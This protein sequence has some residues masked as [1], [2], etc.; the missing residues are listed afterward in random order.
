MENLEDICETTS[1]QEGL[2]F[3]C[4]A[5]RDPRLYVEQFWFSFEGPLDPS[6]LC[7]A[8]QF[9]VD[10]HAILRTSFP[11]QAAERPV[12]VVY[13]TLELPWTELD[14][15]H[16]SSDFEAR[17]DELL[18]TDQALGF[19]LEHLPLLR[20]TLIRQAENRHR[21]IW[22][23]HHI[24]LDG[25]SL[26][27]LFRELD[28]AY[29]A[30]RRGTPPAL[31]QK[32]P[33]RDLARW[34]LARDLSADEQFWRD[35]L[36][37][38]THPTLWTSAVAGGTGGAQRRVVSR[39]LSE[40][41]TAALSRLA[42]EQRLTLG[43]VCQSLWAALAGRHLATTRVVLG[44]AV[45]GR[46]AQLE[47]VEGMVGLFA[48]AVPAVF[49]LDQRPALAWI[50]HQQQRQAI[51]EP[52]TYAPPAKV[53]QWSPFPSGALFDSLFGFENY[54]G[55]DQ[56]L[57]F[58]EGRIS[59]GLGGLF[60]RTNYPVEVIVAPGERLLFRVSF[61]PARLDA[62]TISDLP[63]RF[64]EL[65]RR[66]LSDSQ[67]PLLEL[68]V[69][70]GELERLRNWTR[71]APRPAAL[72]PTP[73][74]GRFEIVEPTTGTPVPVGTAG[75]LMLVSETV[76]PRP[77]GHRAR[78]RVDDT[79][80]HPTIELVADSGSSSRPPLQQEPTR[81]TLA[82]T[83]REQALAVMWGEILGIGTP[84]SVHDSFLSLGGDSILAIRLVA[85]ARREGFVFNA[86]DLF[87]RGTI[88]ELATIEAVTADAP[89]RREEA[90]SAP[91][92]PIQHWFLTGQSAAA[93]HHFN[94][95]VSVE[96]DPS[97]LPHLR[98]AAL[99]VIAHHHLDRTSWLQDDRGR[100]HTTLRPGLAST[101][102]LPFE[103]H[104][105]DGPE[106]QCRG[107]IT[108]TVCTW[109]AALDITK[110]PLFRLGVFS[111]HGRAVVVWVMHHL[112]VDALSWRILI[113]DLATACRQLEQGSPVDLPPVP[114]TFAAWAR[115]RAEQATSERVRSQ[116][117]FWTQ[118]L[119][120]NPKVLELDGPEP[121]APN[122]VCDE[123]EFS[124]RLG[125]APTE[126]LLRGAHAAYGT[127]IND[128]LLTALAH[129]LL[130]AR[131]GIAPATAFRFD[132]EGHGREDRDGFDTSRAVGWF[133]S[134]FP[135][136]L[137]I[138]TTNDLGADLR[139]IKRQLRRIPSHGVDFGLLAELQDP[140]VLAPAPES[141]ILFNYLGQ[142]DGAFS[143]PPVLGLADVPAGPNH[144]G[145]IRR[146]HE[147]SIDCFVH[148]HQLQASWRFS[149]RRI[150]PET[151]RTLA[152]T[153]VEKLEAL[154]AHCAAT[155]NAAPD[156]RTI[157]S[158][159]PL[160][161]PAPLGDRA[162][163]FGDQAGIEDTYP[164]TALQQGLLFDAL[165]APGSGTNIEQ[166][167]FTLHGTLDPGELAAAWDRVIE[168][169]AALRTSIHW[170][171]LRSPVQVVHR[172]VVAPW[173]VEDWRGRF[174]SAEDEQRAV[175]AFLEQDRAREFD[176][177]AAPLSRFSVLR[178]AEDRWEFIWTFHHIVLDGWC[179]PVVLGDL[180]HF[181][182]TDRSTPLPAPGRYGD[183]LAWLGRQDRAATDRF[184]ATYLAGSRAAT[185]LA[186][187]AP[188]TGDP[189]FAQYRTHLPEALS[190][191]IRDLARHAS[192]TPYIVLQ[193]LWSAL[194]HHASGS[195]DVLFAAAVSGRPPELVG[196]EDMVGLFVNTAPVR[197]RL[198]P[199]QP[200]AAWLAELQAEQRDRERHGYLP[201]PELHRHTQVPPDQPL[202]ESLIVYE[203]YPIDEALKQRR[204]LGSTEV[205]AVEG[206]ERIG[207]PLAAIFE[208]GAEL[209]LRLMYDTRAFSGEE[210]ADCAR[211]FATLA[212]RLIDAART[213][214]PAV[215]V[216]LRST[217][218][219]PPPAQRPDLPA[220]EPA[221]VA[222]LARAQRSPH[223]LAV[224]EDGL[225]LTFGQLERASR[226]IALTLRRLGV[227]PEA[228]VVLVLDRSV[229][230]VVGSLG[231]WR[232]GAAF[233][234]V[235]TTLPPARLAQL[236]D[237]ARPTAILTVA[238]H[239]NTV[240]RAVAGRPTALPVIE[241]DHALEA[242]DVPGFAD[243]PPT[244]DQLAYVIFTSGSTGIPKP[245][246][247][248]HR[249]LANLVA[250]HRRT[251]S[252]DPTDRASQSASI[253][254]D[255]SVL[256]IWP[257]LAAG[258]SVH[259][260]P[261]RLMLDP[262][263]LI[264]WLAHESISVCFL[265]TALAVEALDCQWPPMPS[266]RY[267]LTG[268]AKLPRHPPAH[269]PFAVGN[270]YGPT[271]T[272]VVA[273]WALAPA[274]AP[275][276]PSIGAAIDGLSAYV[277][278]E[279][280]EVLPRGTPGELVVGGAG[281]ARGYLG[282]PA[283]TA[284]RFVPNPFG[285]GRLYRTGD[286]VRVTDDGTYEFL[287][288]ID[289]QISL[290]GYRIEPGE[291]EARLNQLET[292]A[293]SLVMLRNPSGQEGREQ[294]VAYVRPADL[295]HDDQQRHHQRWLEQF[296]HTYTA[297]ATAGAPSVAGAS[298]AGWNSS[299]DDQPIS[300]D[301][302]ADWVDS[303][304]A[305]VAALGASRV[306]EIGCG[307]GLL[308]ARLAPDTRVYR[309][310]DYSTEAIARVLELVQSD[311]RLAHVDLDCR[312]A[313]DLRGYH[314]AQFDLVVINSVVQ[315]FAGCEYLEHLLAD[316]APLVSP[317]GRVFVGDVRHLGLLA[318]QHAAVIVGRAE[319]GTSR[320]LLRERLTNR[321]AAEKELC[322]D[323]AFFGAL[324]E[325]RVGYGHA[326]IRLERGRGTTEMARFRYH[327]LLTVGSV[328][329]AP[330]L[331]SLEWGETLR[332]LGMLREQLRTHSGVAVR[333]IPNRRVAGALAAAHW[334]ERDGDSAASLDPEIRAALSGGTSAI[335]PHELF[336]L[337]VGPDRR[338]GL[339]W[340]QEDPGTMDL[341]VCPRQAFP[342]PLS[343]TARRPW[344]SYGNRRSRGGQQLVA[345]LT[346]YLREHLPGYMC[347]SAIVVIDTWPLTPVGKI[348]R[349]ALP[350]PQPATATHRTAAPRPM[351]P[352]EEL[353]AEIWTDVL[354]IAIRDPNLDF[355]G[356]GGHSLSATQV[357]SRLLELRDVRIP[358][359]T[360]FERSTVASLAQFVDDLEWMHG[361]GTEGADSEVITL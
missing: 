92:S 236:I 124:V 245:V 20:L 174:P 338:I 11:W 163:L 303:I 322:I 326:E 43:S 205:V 165:Y 324:V 215:A 97:A 167:Q 346:D 227:G 153:F 70:P 19:D 76:P 193:A 267:L 305:E 285:P 314:E 293:D 161:A 286:L 352:T 184:W 12:Q 185:R 111:F 87:E 159:R 131:P 248:E 47:G 330:T 51:R 38:C 137:E 23:F 196:V 241:L 254:F 67:R 59:V 179:L 291:I 347:P 235:T 88:A 14:W 107:G 302:M 335:E 143:D 200:L 81:S 130:D 203:N 234:P 204:H 199:D 360:V 274:G 323:P 32:R 244:L 339:A 152:Q 117:S 311:P 266:L 149:C 328:P 353:I 89:V 198:H 345:T 110:G 96:V 182:E 219:P 103:E 100:W 36:G 238:R 105:L 147:V 316:L 340:N 202:F 141:Q 109:Q 90:T 5:G 275:G 251:C 102:D 42:R 357:V 313:D 133:T 201:L 217:A 355:F 62:A 41:L 171:R 40:D 177:A 342:P 169:H 206:H 22:T 2:L 136:R 331:T 212:E 252:I 139:A 294:L 27:I 1:R 240:D 113:E 9:L 337:D 104:L 126:T 356:A 262:P 259:I 45:S 271:E 325:A 273:T 315:Y 80:T 69:E 213:H 132:L 187:A 3:E 72:F 233:A 181:Y 191:G 349:R 255:A 39:H 127:Q 341:V 160:P 295:G 229:A 260:T 232:A 333:G 121:Q 265:P 220:L 210:I 310:T 148:E 287:G 230:N 73:D 284:R 66:F 321:V 31:G 278:D 37:S 304:V 175:A 25:W 98:A 50:Q 144:G 34:E 178:L 49:E 246:A 129:T 334:L 309:A 329:T 277:V 35:E 93:V 264:R 361:S 46:P 168:R 123:Q 154:I 158:D 299:Y 28:L 63:R 216:L 351:T 155:A 221:P 164:L 15:S 7:Q 156:E 84:I 64:E 282:N 150:Q 26:P 209:G 288:R 151:I 119:A 140:P 83:P 281:V 10:R 4:L 138:G 263:A 116:Q 56:A 24:L 114:T 183:F 242:A 296:E 318:A 166:F 250:W 118:Q 344:E 106:A 120:G 300:V 239:R 237:L 71:L 173:T 258:A 8:W 146:R 91:L 172:K 101:A 6:A 21:L 30:I 125:A 53:Q 343:T 279:A 186:R 350:D 354:G 162:D 108:T 327:A 145:S 207:C 52:H 55:G 269:I 195:H 292:V 180:L 222:I 348:D 13:R 247:I 68:V 218:P 214:E 17:F 134:L 283:E 290:R 48:G 33:Y 224:V 74:A 256:E 115:A 142:M 289:D 211:R 192:V 58:D 57:V 99:A 77:T 308:V 128:L 65:C 320:A 54:P 194:L 336:A 135:V 82:S 122:L 358:V 86:R 298:T 225:S 276:V 197:A 306:L 243:T 301:D 29:Q 188:A 60:E 79:G 257:H 44:V 18:T 297:G 75:E 16:D 223:A 359:R 112:L 231:V 268:G 95:S 319:N 94:Q 176:L 85:R 189:V 170:E 272:S 190:E 307:S 208:P 261:E 280:L 228:T 270:N 332:D 78:L 61:D 157:G 317:G 249:G 226:G 312:A 253:A